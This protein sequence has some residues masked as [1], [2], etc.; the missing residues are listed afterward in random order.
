MIEANRPLTPE[1]DSI[2]EKVESKPLII[3]INKIDLVDSQQP[4]SLP[5]AWEQSNVVQISALYGL[6]L[7]ILKK[8]IAQTVV[9][10]NPLER[11]HA[12]VPN[13]RHKRLLDISLRAAESII[14]QLQ[15]DTPFELVTIY[16]QEAIDALG[17]ILGTN[18][19]VD[20]L[21]QIFSQFCIGK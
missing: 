12:I 8:K 6:G 10:E 2:Y 5:A 9:G 17:E 21:E 3:V 7:E 13:L 19:K 11:G 1:D 4:Y 15:E 16:M 14:V 18:A 20:V